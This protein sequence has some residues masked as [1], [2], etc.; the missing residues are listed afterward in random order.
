MRL[1]SITPD[2]PVAAPAQPTG[3]L[4]ARIRSTAA[5]TCAE[6]RTMKLTRPVGGRHIADLDP[7][8]AAAKIA[9]NFFFLGRK[10]LLGASRSSA[11]RASDCRPQDR[12]PD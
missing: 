5:S 6:S 8:I 4:K 9:G 12:A 11:S 1:P 3:W 7:R 10:A 2:V